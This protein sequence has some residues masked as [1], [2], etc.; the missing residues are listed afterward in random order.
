MLS[1]YII[2]LLCY[3]C[4]LSQTLMASE[5]VDGIR[6]F[7]NNGS[8]EQSI[9]MSQALLGN[10]TLKDKERFELLSLIADA[11]EM[12][13]QAQYYDDISLA[14]NAIKALIKEF[15]DRIDAPELTWRLAWLHWKHGDEK[16]ALKY[17][18]ELRSDYPNN[19][20]SVQAAM[21][22]ARIYIGQRKWN[23]AR[24]S[25]IQYGLGVA[26]DSRE[27]ALAKAWLAVVDIAEGRNVI[28]LKQLDGAFKKYP[29]EVRRD[30]HLWFT[31]IQLLHMGNRDKEAMKQADGFLNDYLSGD[32]VALVRLLR[33]DLWLLHRAKSLDRIEREYDLLAEQEAG[34]KLGKKAFMRKLMIAHQ[35][36]QDYHTLKPVIIALKGLADRNQLSSIENEAQLDLARLWRRLNHSDPKRSPKQIDMVSLDLF[37]RVAHSEIKD[38][39]AVA[40][41]EGIIFFE[42]KLQEFLAAEKWVE[43]VAIWERFPVFRRDNLDVARLQLGVA[44][45]LRMLMAYEQAEVLLR[46]LYKRANGSVWGQ[47]VMLERARLWLDRGDAAG[48]G[49][50][51]AWL[52]E[53]E[54]TLYRPEMLLL[55]ARMQ[56]QENKPTAASQSIIA[57][58]VDDIT[59]EERLTYWKVRAGIAEK[60]K[61]WHMA[62]RAWQEYVFMPGADAAMG[63]IEQ[64]NNVFKAK[65]YQKAESLYAQVDEKRRDAAW[66]YHYS[67]CQLKTGKYKQALESLEAQSQDASAGIYA[68]LAA[69][70]IVDKKAKTLLKEYP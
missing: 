42:Q 50:V 49:R 51:L 22:M 31:Y 19:K 48:V 45:A 33:A 23:E 24:S 5:R 16:V 17:A 46:K 59:I 55:V 60:L 43:V 44:H 38:Y 27:E 58:A 25:L 11:Q 66:L 21:L 20:E 69:L 40:L 34:E 26:L 13:S 70:A 9:R 53:H 15:P 63:L 56:L 12:R 3:M 36:S 67:I 30:E 64:A 62:A 54:F 39:R 10:E 2:L 47:K 41:H 4:L 35:N 65:D 68:S 57:I 14:V 1:K 29:N 61:H 18:R 52:D 6:V 37:S 32:Y 8:P 7:L 28:A